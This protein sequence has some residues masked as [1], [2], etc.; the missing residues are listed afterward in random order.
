[1]GVARPPTGYSRVIIMAM[2]EHP[3][4]SPEIAS[5]RAL[6]EGDASPHAPLGEFNGTLDD[7]LRWARAR[8]PNE[9]LVYDP[10][11]RELVQ[12]DPRAQ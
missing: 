2:I 11:T 12:V 9:L 8:Q 10:A 1:M 5:W 4:R 6:W 3:R 7:A